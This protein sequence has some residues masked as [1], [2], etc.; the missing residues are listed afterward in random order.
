MLPRREKSSILP[1]KPTKTEPSP[2]ST[3]SASAH[4]QQGVILSKEGPGH[5][6]LNFT[7]K[8]VEDYRRG[9]QQSQDKATYK[10]LLARLSGFISW[11]LGRNKRRSWM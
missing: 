11:V 10:S 5:T 3:R 2:E 7:R 8:D 4:L 1:R 9:R 6:W